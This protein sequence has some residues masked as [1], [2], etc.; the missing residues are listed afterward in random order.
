MNRRQT[1]TAYEEKVAA[2]LEKKG[3]CILERNYRCRQGEIDL[4]ARDGRYLVFVEVKY[5]SG[6]KTGHPVE[7]VHWRKQQRIIQTAMYYCYQHRIPDT[8]PC[9]FDVVTVLGDQTEHI[10]NAFEMQA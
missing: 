2:F 7:A 1:G 9:R 6:Q 10:E 3:F 8:Q 4:V 5:R